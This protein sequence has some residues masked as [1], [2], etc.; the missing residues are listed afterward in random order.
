MMQLTYR[1]RLYPSRA[2]EEKMLAALDECRWIYNHFLERLNRKENGKTPSRYELQATL[3]KLKQERPELKQVHSKVLQMVLHQ[4][5]LNLRVLAQLKRNGRRVGR[6]RFKGRGW[7]KSFTYNQSGLK[8]IEGHGKRR[9]LWLSKVG[10][11]PIVLHHE[12]DGEAKQVHIKQE[13]SGKWFACFSVEVE[14]APRVERASKPVGIDLGITHY[15]AD[16]DG[17]F[18]E[19]PHTI[20]KSEQRLKWEQRKLSRK[21]R[22]SKNRAKQRIRLARVYERVRNQRLDFLH[23]LSRCYVNSHDFIAVENLD[24]KELIEMAHNGKNRADAAWATFLHMLTYKAERAGRWA[25]KVEPRGTT[26]RCSRCGEMVEKPLWVRVHK[27]PNCG[28]ELDRDLNAAR[29]IL[30]DGLK[31]VGWEP[32]EFAPVEIGP[33][34]ARASLIIEA[35]SPVL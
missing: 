6:L 11:I 19:H 15:V 31:Q 17:N 26:D 7:F 23:K 32:A 5:Y 12:L 22:G 14:E 29:N 24:V 34:P 28:L 25:V 9:E 4:L 27:C 3:P 8:V 16:T 35:G 18:V 2:Q 10:S 20:I 1:F 13:R 33:L 30:Q 21:K